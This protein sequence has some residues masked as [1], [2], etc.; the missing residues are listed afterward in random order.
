VPYFFK[1]TSPGGDEA[2]YGP[3]DLEDDANTCRDAVIEDRPDHTVEALFQ[4]SS[5]Y[6]D[7]LPRPYATY[8]MD[9]GSTQE[10]WTDGSSKI[11]PAE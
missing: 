7:T 5:N 1:S 10:L 8:S 3:F 11:I 2:V 9:D 4:E 6:L